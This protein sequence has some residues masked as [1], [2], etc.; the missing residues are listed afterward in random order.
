[1]RILGAA[2]LPVISGILELAPAMEAQQ[3]SV[4]PASEVTITSSG[5]GTP[6]PA[7][8]YVPRGALL[9][10]KS[11]PVPL[12]VFLHSWSSDY[13]SSENMPEALKE[14]RQRGW[15][16]ISPDFRGPN[17]RPEACA[18]DLAVQDVLD[19]IRYAK[20]QGRVDRKRIYLVGG[21]GGGHMALV[22]ASRAPDLWAAVSAW[23]PITDLAAWHRFSRATN[24]RYYH[25]LEQCCGGPP[26]IPE[27]D[28]QYRRRSPLF[29]LAKAKSVRI[30]ID[31]GIHDGHT[32]SVP[33]SHSLHAF[34]ELAKV[35]G[36]PDAT[37]SE[38]DIEAMTR[39]ARI[40]NHLTG[41]REKERARNHGT[42][43]FRRAAGPVQLTIFEGG[44]DMDIHAAVQWL[45]STSGSSGPRHR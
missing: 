42:T 26:G 28:E 33:I 22:M 12:L 21:S 7:L 45:A 39:D 16:F 38:E 34:N 1:V 8:F 37:L 35:N 6:Q 14:C 15:V 31:V 10:G 2:V 27:A 20:S 18:S 29:S 40:P 23:V 32:G 24:S 4:V 25:M 11:S 3:L 5:D 36:H 30:A 43:L 9:S 44:H 19:S 13:R 41:Q 17:S